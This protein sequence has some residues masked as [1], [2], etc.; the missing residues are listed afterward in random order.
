MAL[1]KETNKETK[2]PLGVFEETG[3]LR[4]V[5]LWGAPGAEAALGQ[6]L[7][8]NQSLFYDSFDVPLARGE[9]EN[10]HELLKKEGV[11]VILVKDLFAE[12]IREKEAGQTADN[13][14][15]ELRKFAE[16]TYEKNKDK[17]ILADLDEVRDWIRKS[18]EADVASYGENAAVIINSTLSLG[19]SLPMANVIYARDQSNLMGKTWVWSS[20]RWQIRQPEVSLYKGI[21][22]HAGLIDSNLK[23]VTVSSKDAWFEGGDGIVFKGNCYIGVGGRTNIKGVLEVADQILDQDMRLFIPLD[24]GRDASELTEMDAMHLDTIWMPCGENDV[25]ACMPEVERR[26]VVEVTKNKKGD[27][28]AKET[29]SFLEH[30]DSLGVNIL[31][32]DKE[33][34]LNFAPNFLNLGKNKIVLSLPT[35]EGGLAA[36]L[37]KRG[38]TVYNA[39]L[40]NITRGYGGLHCMSA[41]IR[42]G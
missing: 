18:I 21:L 41:P 5:L 35:T 27:L 38:K 19:Q 30:L 36:K 17:P 15:L 3:E 1:P 28:E 13:L 33:E 9:F 12:S 25:V 22:E 10:A 8:T 42:R 4:T 34:Q 11:E 39:N 31:E 37:A 20:M 29:G 14:I 2:M 32:I 6:L 16:E 24:K 26:C 7:P 23:A 40:L